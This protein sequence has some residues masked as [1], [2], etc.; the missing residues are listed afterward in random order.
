ML[1]ALARR[2]LLSGF[3]LLASICI[4]LA[5]LFSG[6]DAGTKPSGRVGGDR[7]EAGKSAAKGAIGKP[8]SLQGLTVDDKSVISA[9]ARSPNVRRD[10]IVRMG[11]GEVQEMNQM[12]SAVFDDAVKQWNAQPRVKALVAEWKELEEAWKTRDDEAKAA[13]V[14]RIEAM[15]KEAIGLLRAE[16]EKSAREAGGGVK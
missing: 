16:V 3:L 11:V 9:D 1:V 14:P 8:R 6:Q 12:N 2:P 5:W 7:G 13:D 15:W 10:S 4:A